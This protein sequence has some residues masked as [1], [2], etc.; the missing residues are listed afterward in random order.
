MKTSVIGYPRIG[1]QRELK[2]ATEQY[3][4]KAI[5]QEEL[6]AVASNLRKEHWQV[7]KNHGIDFIASND[8]F[9]LR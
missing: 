9:L 1:S 7:Q 2:F 3:F 6:Q 8:F 4:K 5:T